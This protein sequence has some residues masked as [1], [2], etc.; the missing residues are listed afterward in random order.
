MIDHLEQTRFK[1]QGFCVSYVSE[2]VSISIAHFKF[3][4][5]QDIKFASDVNKRNRT[6]FWLIGRNLRTFKTQRR[7]FPLSHLT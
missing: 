6:N 3:T 2:L 7:C 1:K 5:R 4:P